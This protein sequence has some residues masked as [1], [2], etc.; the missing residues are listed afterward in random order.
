M[1]RNFE[2]YVP[3]DTFKEY[4]NTMRA[5]TV[6]V[7]LDNGISQMVIQ[8]TPLL[9][10]DTFASA[11]ES[12]ANTCFDKNGKYIAW[13][14]DIAFM[15]VVLSSYTNLTVPEKLKD[16]FDLLVGTDVYRNVVDVIDADQFYMLKAAVSKKIR[17]TME[18]NNSSREQELDRA[19]TMLNL[20][21][22]KYYEIGTIFNEVMGDDMKALMEKLRDHAKDV[23]GEVSSIRDALNMNG[24]ANN[25]SAKNSTN[26]EHQRST[27]DSDAGV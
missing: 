10:M 12:V 24:E 7:T 25:S 17:A 2:S 16:E 13:V 1:T 6:D 21:T 15:H 9:D 18:E 20:I 5:K 8:V 27:G 22:Q 3:V 11:V 23:S 19:L 14:K 4:Y 26:E